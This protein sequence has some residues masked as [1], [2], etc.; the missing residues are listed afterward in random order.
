MLYSLTVSLVISEQRVIARRVRGLLKANHLTQR[1]LADSVGMSE[2]AMSN[3]LRGL[4]NFTLRDMSRI[5]DYFDVSLDY[6]TGRSDYA[7]PLEVA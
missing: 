4:K 2:Q 7:K 1:E 3:K 5:A 6:L